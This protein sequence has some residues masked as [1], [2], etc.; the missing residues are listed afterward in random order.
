MFLF[1]VTVFITVDLRKACKPDLKSSHCHCCS[2]QNNPLYLTVKE[3]THLIAFINSTSF[4]EE[5]E[6]KV[7][8]IVLIFK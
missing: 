8:N 2:R 3:V 5:N 1:S 7:L 6:N 4:P